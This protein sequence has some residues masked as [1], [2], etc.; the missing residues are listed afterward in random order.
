MNEPARP[1]EGYEGMKA[2]KL[3]RALGNDRDL[4]LEIIELFERDAPAMLAAVRK[5][6]DFGDRESLAKA[7]HVLKGSTANFG[8]SPLYEVTREIEICAYD[9]DASRMPALTERFETAADGFMRALAQ[10]KR[11]V[12]A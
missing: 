11:E 9:G 7:A 2:A 5:H 3:L 10:L 4:L 12:T 8:K 6:A 1:I